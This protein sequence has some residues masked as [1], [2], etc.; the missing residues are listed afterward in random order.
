[1]LWIKIGAALPVKTWLTQVV[2]QL[3]WV[4]PCGYPHT[5]ASVL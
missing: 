3:L 4:K 5:G 2:Q 1:M